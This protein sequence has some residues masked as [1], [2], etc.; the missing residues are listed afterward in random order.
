LSSS[1]QY[2]V[3]NITNERLD[4]STIPALQIDTLILAYAKDA[5][6]NGWLQTNPA[7]A[8]VVIDCPMDK[9]VVMETMLGRGNVQ[10]VEEVEEYV[11]LLSSLGADV[12]YME[13]AIK[14]Y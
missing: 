4:L 6:K 1:A 5:E 11:K 8:Y 13:T 3:L 10:F 14:S 9:V 7:G 2:A 12:R